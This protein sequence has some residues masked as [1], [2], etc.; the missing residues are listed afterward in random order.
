MPVPTGYSEASLQVYML[1]ATGNLGTVLGLTISDFVEAVTD[2][3]IAYGEEDIADATEIGKLRALAKVA[4]WQVAVAKSSG[5]MKFQ[6]DG[7]SFEAQQIHAQ[8]LAGLAL[9]E[10][11]AATYTGGM[12]GYEV[13]TATFHHA[14]DPYPLPTDE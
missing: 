13:T 7:G 11:M 10:T 6:A 8:A 2:T 12:V 9:A 14:N 4:A 3:L 1:A 5:Y